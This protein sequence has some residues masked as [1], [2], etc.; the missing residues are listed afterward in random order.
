MPEYGIFLIS[1][2]A[3]KALNAMNDTTKIS[4]QLLL[5]F[6]VAVFASINYFIAIAF[7]NH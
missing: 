6:T 2:I 4:L 5:C 3:L 1:L 7:V